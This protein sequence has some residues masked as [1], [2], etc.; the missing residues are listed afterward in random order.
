M[1]LAIESIMSSQ[2]LSNKGNFFLLYPK[3]RNVVGLPGVHRDD[4]FPYLGVNE[5]GVVAG[6]PYKFYKMISAGEVYTLIGLRPVQSFK[7]RSSTPSGRASDYEHHIPE[8]ISR[9]SEGDKVLFELLTPGYKRDWARHIYSAR[10][11]ATRQKRLGEMIQ[12]LRLG[13]KNI[14]AYHRARKATTSEQ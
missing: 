12:A 2:C 11:E 14:D 6:T 10:G 8:L 5:E 4:I 1:R 9:L 7:P 3:L 13:H